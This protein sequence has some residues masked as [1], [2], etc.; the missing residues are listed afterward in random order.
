MNVFGL[1]SPAGKQAEERSLPGLFIY[2]GYVLRCMPKK[3]RPR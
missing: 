2:R 3:T 1:T